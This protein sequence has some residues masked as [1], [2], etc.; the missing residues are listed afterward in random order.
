MMTKLKG[1]RRINSINHQQQQVRLFGGKG[2]SGLKERSHCSNSIKLN[3]FTASPSSSSSLFSSF[4]SLSTK[5]YSTNNNILNNNNEKKTIGQEEKERESL[6]NPSSENNSNSVKVKEP[7]T[8]QRVQKWAKTLPGTIREGAHHYWMGSKLLVLETKIT[9]SIVRRILKGH[10]MTRRERRQLVRT[11][12]D[13]F[14]VVPFAVIAIIPF[15]EFALPLLLKFFPNMLPSTFE[16]KLK[17]EELL[18]KKLKAKIEVAKFLQDAAVELGSKQMKEGLTFNDFMQKV[19]SGESVSNEEIIKF[20][21]IFEDEFTLDSLPRPVLVGMCKFLSLPPYGGDSFLRFQ[22]IQKLKQLKQDDKMIQDEGVNTLNLEELQQAL[23]ARGMRGTSNSKAFLR[24]KLSEWLDLS[25]K[26]NLPESILILSRAM[27]ITE[28]NESSQIA[29]KET[30]SSL[31]DDLLDEVKLK[32]AKDKVTRLDKFEA[33][34]K[35]NELIEEELEAKEQLKLEQ[36]SKTNP[37]SEEQKLKESITEAVSVLAFASPVEKERNVVKE[38]KAE[39]EKQKQTIEMETPEHVSGSLQNEAPSKKAEN[40]HDPKVVL[41]EASQEEKKPEEKED[42][43]SKTTKQLESRLDLMVQALEKEVETIEQTLGTKLNILDKDNDGVISTA[44]LES[45][46]SL[47]NE[48]ISPE[49][50]QELLKQFDS[51]RDGKISL[52]E[53]LSTINQEKGSKK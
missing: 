24:Q 28:K 31:P 22:L 33:M 4:Y 14:R 48:K 17:K 26:H 15:L 9:M 43:D 18:R 2:F 53:I 32:V 6:D 25:L 21:A 23:R 11:V 40:V 42:S 20:A 52:K 8:V 5:H 37:D 13:M 10:V 3:H 51:D 47:L 1:L 7:W 35:Q 38:L 30:I 34:E 45:A 41:N 49:K 39:R 50:Y 44:E 36:I 27:T 12:S 46:I 19:R 29:L 16:D